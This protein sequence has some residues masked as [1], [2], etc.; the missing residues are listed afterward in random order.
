MTNI[1]R[2]KTALNGGLPDRIPV[3]AHIFMLAIRE[4][5]VTHREFRENP[6]VMARVMA[7]VTEKYD[8]DG[9]FF[10]LDTTLLASACGAE[11]IYPENAPAVVKGVQPRSLKQLIDD[12][13]GVDLLASPRVRG[14]L[15]AVERLSAWGREHDRY[16]R[17][18]AGQGPFSL[19]CLVTGMDEFMVSLADEDCEEDVR[20]LI[21]ATLAV[22]IR[23]HE[24]VFKAGAPSMSY[25]NSSEG[26]SVI[27]PRMFRKFCK[28]PETRLAAELRRRGIPTM[29]HICGDVG[30]ILPDLVETGCPAYELDWL[31]DVKRIFELAHG[32]F[33]L[34]GNVNPTLFSTGTPDEVYAA[35]KDVCDLYRGK[36]GLVLCSG[37]AIGPDT[38]EANMRA[39][40]R[41]GRDGA[42]EK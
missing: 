37:C 2:V 27:S 36:G 35:A 4:A 7:A 22:S 33:V 1:E 6:E 31:T 41:A 38:P 9:V 28:E 12:I 13:S 39:F 15:E 16:I 23:M 26:C 24:L 21:D 11:V 3:M 17:A 20:R 32:K 30:P 29:C 25:G 5:G 10:D 8:L 42:S 34:S 14:Y 40:V 18:T 19:A